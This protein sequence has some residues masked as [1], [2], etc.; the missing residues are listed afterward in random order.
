MFA[1]AGVASVHACVSGE[2]SAVYYF[3]SPAIATVKDV[4]AGCTSADAN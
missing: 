2:C 4:W 1:V 3:E